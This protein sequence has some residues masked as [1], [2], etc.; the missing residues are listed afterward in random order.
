MLQKE[1]LRKSNFH[2][3]RRMA[4]NLFWALPPGRFDFSVLDWPQQKHCFLFNK[5]Y[6]PWK[7]FP[8]PVEQNHQSLFSF[9]DFSL[10]TLGPGHKKTE[11]NLDSNS[12][13]GE[14][15]NNPL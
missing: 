13:A 5:I 8:L 9:W 6:C 12:E 7:G 1:R 2:L 14:T 4:L 15:G 3:E 10:D 11:C